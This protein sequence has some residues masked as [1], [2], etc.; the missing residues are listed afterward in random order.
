[1]QPSVISVQ[2]ICQ[3]LQGK[4]RKKTLPIFFIFTI[5]RNETAAA[6]RGSP[7][8]PMPL[9]CAQNEPIELAPSAGN[10]LVAFLL[11]RRFA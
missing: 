2:E 8:A 9:R 11:T 1:M 3:L 6:E 7:V 5:D 4:F 10:L